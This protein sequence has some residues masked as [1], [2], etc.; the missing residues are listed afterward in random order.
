MQGAT[1][2]GRDF[3]HGPILMQDD[4]SSVTGPKAHLVPLLCD[5]VAAR[6]YLAS[7]KILS[8]CCCS[9]VNAVLPGVC[10]V[11]VLSTVVSKALR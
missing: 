7:A 2:R 6:G 4:S 5:W 1:Q 9:A 3:D 10:L 11:S 8:V